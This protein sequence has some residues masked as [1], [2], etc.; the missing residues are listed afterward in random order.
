MEDERPDNVAEA[1]KRWRACDDIDGIRRRVFRALRI[2]EEVA[3]SEGASRSERLKACTVMQ[4]TARTY[5][6]VIEADELL[7]RVE[8]L[9]QAQEAAKSNGKLHYN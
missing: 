3:Y 2:A 1:L 6:K 8:A 9:E 7:E 5:L 4:Q